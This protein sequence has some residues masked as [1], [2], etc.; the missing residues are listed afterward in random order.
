MENQIDWY[1]DDEKAMDNVTLGQFE[2]LCALACKQKAK[3]DELE[4]HAKKEDEKLKKLKTQ[5]HNVFQKFGKKSYKSGSGDIT[6]VNLETFLTPKTKE[7]KEALLNYMKSLSEDVYWAKIGVNHQT[8]QAFCKEEM[9]QAL[10]RGETTFR[11]PGVGEPTI[12]P[13]I[14]IKLSKGN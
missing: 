7:E 12:I 1:A 3:V 4:D 10:E 6:L 8:L 5:I 14:R 11:V 9:N 13:Q 2:E